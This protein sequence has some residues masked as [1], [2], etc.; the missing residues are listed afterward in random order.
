MQEFMYNLLVQSTTCQLFAFKNNILIWES[1]SI[2]QKRYALRSH[3]TNKK[4]IAFVR[5]RV[6]MKKRVWIDNN[7]LIKY[8]IFRIRLLRLSTKVITRTISNSVSIHFLCFYYNFIFTNTFVS[9]GHI[10]RTIGSP[11]VHC[12]KAIRIIMKLIMISSDN[13]AVI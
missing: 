8:C 5:A 10:T 6:I 1:E 4:I 2:C 12:N 13:A 9:L 3:F 11:S 7:T